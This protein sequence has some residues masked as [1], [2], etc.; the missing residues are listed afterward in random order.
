MTMRTTGTLA[1]LA[2]AIAIASPAAGTEYVL[3][4]LHA[5][6]QLSD[7][8][9]VARVDDPARA[10]MTVEQVLKGTPSKQI[11]LTEYVDGFLRPADRKPLA[12][13]AKELLFLNRKGEAYAPVQTEFGRFRVLNDRLVDPIGP[14]RMLSAVVR[15]IKRLVALQGRAGVN[16]VEADRAY[17]DALRDLDPQVQSWGIDTVF[18]QIK[19]PSVALADTLLARW[20]KDAGSIAN[21]M[22]RWRLQRASPLFAQ[23]LRT[24]TVPIERGLAAMA[25]GAAGDVEYLPLL[26]RAA[27]SEPDGNARA[28]AYNGIMWMVGPGALNDLRNGAGD[29]D[30]QV[31]ARCVV[32]SYNL[33]ELEQPER[34]WPPA[35][36]ALIEQVRAFLT[37]MQ[38]DPERFVSDNAKSMLSLIARHQP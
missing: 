8:I 23:T 1:I 30:K 20:P 5:R 2:A 26:R 13:D 11:G 14:E 38:Q 15:S 34:R 7:T 33:L 25:L 21:A 10:L 16:E 18:Q 28:L 29:P 12:A 17:I 19:S 22:I 4:T 36:R 32:D 31:R 3:L 24:S 9:V 35:S 37:E 27:A 6:V